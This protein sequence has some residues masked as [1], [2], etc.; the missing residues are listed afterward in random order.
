MK[1][2]YQQIKELNPCYDPI[3]IG[4]KEDYEDSVVNFIKEYRE[5]VKSKNDIH[6]VLLRKEF[7]TVKELRL[8]AVW[9]ARKVQH[10]MTDDRSIKAL[11]VAE[12]FANGNATQEE[13]DSGADAADA[14]WAAL[15]AADAARAALAA[16]DAAWAAADA[17]RAALAAAR[18]ALAAADAARAALAAADAAW[19]AADAARAAADAGAAADAAWAALAAAD[20]ARAALAA[21]LD[22]LIE[23]FTEKSIEV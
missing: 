14:A 1:I 10:L 13:L 20:A 18:A 2:S 8:F 5:K 6:W 4:M 23:I 3:E 12:A 19:A 9:S 16:A 22:R 15:A 11:D 21:Q 7:L 17:A